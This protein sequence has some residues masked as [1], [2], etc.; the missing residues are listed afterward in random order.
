MNKLLILLVAVILAISGIYLY[1]KRPPVVSKT[2]ETIAHEEIPQFWT[3]CNKYFNAGCSRDKLPSQ[4]SCDKAKQE[5]L[6][7][8]PT[9]ILLDK[10]DCKNM[11]ISCNIY[12]NITTLEPESLGVKLTC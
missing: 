1:P 10:M 4:E 9:D 11:E 12:L 2:N 5:L 8:L 3:E 7:Y 6:P